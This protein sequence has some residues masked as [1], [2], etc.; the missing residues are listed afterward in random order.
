M[1]YT[2]YSESLSNH[3]T[4][5][6]VFDAMMGQGKTQKII[7]KINET[8][9][10]Q[11][12]IYITPLLS[13]AHRIAGTIY[14][15]DDTDKKPLRCDL[16]RD[17]I[18]KVDAPLKDR[19]FKH[20]HYSYAGGKAQSLPTL[21]KDKENVTTTHQLFVNLTQELLEGVQDYILIVDEALEIYQVLTEYPLTEIKTMLDNK[22]LSIGADKC[23]LTFHRENYAP[24]REAEGDS[25]H[26]TYYSRFATLCDLKQVTLIDD[27]V[28]VWELPDT[29]L[30]AFKEVWIGTY[31]FEGSLFSLYLKNR[32][33]DYKVEKFGKK[34]SDIKHLIKLYDST[35][36]GNLNEIGEE[37]NALCSSDYKRNRGITEGKIAA[38]STNLDS[39]LRG[40]K[41]KKDDRIFTC[42]K[43]D[44]SKVGKK[45]KE[46]WLPCNTK[47]TND[48]R[49]THTVAYLCNIYPIQ[50]I[51]KAA[52]KKGNSFSQEQ[53][54]LSEMIQFIF[55]SAI[56]QGEAINL[57]VPSSRMRTVLKNW[58]NDEYEDLPE[59]EAED[60]DNIL[61]E[62]EAYQKSIYTM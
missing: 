26:N 43:P 20:P 50:N 35:K 3:T 30:R 48:Y 59:V 53:F 21:I 9:I 31:M 45:Y 23:T 22:W 46:Q 2:P 24:F 16:T 49:N 57:Y 40:T 29:L 32:G 27:K 54:A 5:I 1:T 34:P 41:A 17:Y 37:V 25:T 58:L 36:K 61:T 8:E 38:V 52:S 56:R 47:A 44:L 60:V 14:S 4:S 12:F 11:K 55:R 51:A 39:F 42:F 10:T 13:E 18:Y 7:S 15:E 28:I 6:T 33:L 62:L 19:R